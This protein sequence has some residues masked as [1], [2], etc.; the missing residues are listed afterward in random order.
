MFYLFRNILIL[1]KLFVLVPFQ[2]KCI[3][4]PGFYGKHC[5]QQVDSCFGNP[6]RNG[7]KCIVKLGENKLMYEG[8]FKCI[9]LRGF[10]GERL[11]IILKN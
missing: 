8:R 7:G 10:A 6:C 11:G 9:C 1:N 5:E 4:S 3:C 2:F